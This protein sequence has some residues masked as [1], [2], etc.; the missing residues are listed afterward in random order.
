MFV[1]SSSFAQLTHLDPVV[2]WKELEYEFPSEQYA[3]A[4]LDSGQ[5]VPGNGVPIDVAV[6]Y[7][8]MYLL[9]NLCTYY[10]LYMFKKKSWF[11]IIS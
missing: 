3:Q 4:A 9:T 7:R 8:S 5:Y 10:Y 6:D 1:C 2:E 11:S